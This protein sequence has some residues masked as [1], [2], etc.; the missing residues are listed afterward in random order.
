M[1]YP[2]V[3]VKTFFED[4]AGQKISFEATAGRVSSVGPAVDA[5]IAG[6]GLAI[7]G[8]NLIKAMALSIVTDGDEIAVVR[9]CPLSLQQRL[10]GHGM[11]T[12]SLVCE[13]HVEL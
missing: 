13:K 8:P 6:K 5:S 3:L 9:R 11:H 10:A 7:I 2:N 1:F 12:T 4:E